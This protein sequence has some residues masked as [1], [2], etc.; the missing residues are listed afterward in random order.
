[1][2]SEARSMAV[3]LLGTEAEAG[4]IERLPMMVAVGAGSGLMGDRP[5]LL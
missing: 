4:E 3:T 1:M 2:A 5:T